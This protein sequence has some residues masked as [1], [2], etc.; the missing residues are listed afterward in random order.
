MNSLDDGLHVLI[1]LCEC[2]HG[3]VLRENDFCRT[4][5]F[6]FCSLLFYRG[7]LG[8]ELNNT[9]EEPELNNTL[10]ELEL[11]NTLEEAEKMI[12]LRSFPRLSLKYCEASLSR[13]LHFLAGY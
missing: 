8:P 5:L 6:P 4:C 11:N 10:E 13:H 2:F 1:E 3:L 9:L 12:I 7:G